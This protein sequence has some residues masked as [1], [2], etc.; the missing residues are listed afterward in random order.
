[1]KILS[2]LTQNV[3]RYMNKN[4]V[5][6]RYNRHMDAAVASGVAAVGHGITTA[7]IPGLVPLSQIHPVN[8]FVNVGLWGLYFK[9]LGLAIANRIEM[10]PIRKRALAIKKAV[11]LAKKG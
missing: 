11:K 6:A 1:M 4:T 8:L 2:K 3:S 10:R 7:T 9:N 5:R